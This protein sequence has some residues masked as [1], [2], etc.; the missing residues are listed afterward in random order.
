MRKV[1]LIA[2]GLVS[3]SVFGNVQPALARSTW[4]PEACTI[5]IQNCQ[6]GPHARS[7]DTCVKGMAWCYKQAEID[8]AANKAAA[9]LSSQMKKDYINHAQS[10]TGILGAGKPPKRAQ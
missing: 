9:Q 10:P 1:L 4:T 8:V 3:F 6:Q 5:A 2:F 7:H